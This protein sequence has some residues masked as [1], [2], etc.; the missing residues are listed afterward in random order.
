M[1]FDGEP[2]SFEV[3]MLDGQDVVV[4]RPLGACKLCTYEL[5]DVYVIILRNS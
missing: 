4:W 5:T 2:F 1:E 3:R